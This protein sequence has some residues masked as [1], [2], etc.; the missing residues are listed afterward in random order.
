M[1]KHL[2]V[3]YLKQGLAIARQSAQL[4]EALNDSWGQGDLDQISA[5]LDELTTFLDSE[6]S[7]AL[8]SF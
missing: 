1:G 5:K 6:E 3:S 8:M 4:T 2:K 7:K